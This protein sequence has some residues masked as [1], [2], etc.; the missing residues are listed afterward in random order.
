MNSVARSGF[1]GALPAQRSPDREMQRG[2]SP[3]VSTPFS[4]KESPP[5]LEAECSFS[6][7]EPHASDPAEQLIEAQSNFPELV[8]SSSGVS[9]VSASPDAEE[10]FLKSGKWEVV[11]LCSHR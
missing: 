11:L 2:P 3:L 5:I 9:E 10:R 4:T 1:E 6:E 7:L 8:L